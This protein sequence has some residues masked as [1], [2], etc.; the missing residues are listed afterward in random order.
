MLSQVPVELNPLIY[1]T[2]FVPYGPYVEELKT[3][4]L[5]QGEFFKASIQ[6]KLLWAT[7]AKS[8]KPEISELHFK[9]SK[10]YRKLRIFMQIHSMPHNYIGVSFAYS[11]KGGSH[12]IQLIVLPPF[13]NLPLQ[14]FFP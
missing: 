5:E 4:R 10:N 9:H 2:R 3:V 8:I 1:W 11:A 14:S 7:N 6:N 13:D 12:S